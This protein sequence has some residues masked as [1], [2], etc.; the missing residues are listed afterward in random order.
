MF[1]QVD[2]WAAWHYI[3][4]FLIYFTGA[5]QVHVVVNGCFLFTLCVLVDY[6]IR[7]YAQRDLGFLLLL[8]VFFIVT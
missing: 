4:R 2:P 7:K 5:D 6:L 8:V 3:L 1:S